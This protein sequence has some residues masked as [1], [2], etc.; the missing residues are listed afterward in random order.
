VDLT[1][2]TAS[3]ESARNLK[4]DLETGRVR[5]YRYDEYD[6]MKSVMLPKHC[7][8][9][10][11]TL[12]GRDTGF[13]TSVLARQATVYKRLRKKI[14]AL[15]PE[16]VELSRKWL[17]G[18]EIHLQDAVDYA[19]DLIRGKTPEDRIYLKKIRNRRDVAAAVLIDASSSTEET[20]SGRRI[21][22]IEKDA[23]CLLGQTLAAVGDDFGL[24]SFASNGRHGVF[25]NVVKDFADP[26]GPPVQARIGAIEA[27]ASN[28]DGCA[29]RHAS[30]VLAS[31][32]H[33]TKLLLLL[34]DG[35]PADVDYGSASNIETSQYAIEDT[36]QAI[37]DAKK[38][39]I[40]PYCLTIDRTA[41]DYIARLYGQ[42]HFQ[43]L[44][45]I[46]RLPEK[47][48]KLYL[49]LTR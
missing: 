47:L 44:S 39:G 36:R 22:D 40:V 7:T 1:A 25:F 42:Y 33:K 24:Y 26:W 32:P 45:D 20:V 30:A 8:L 15:K 6:C 5:V 18:D 29:V 11:R 34:S 23:V 9:Y 48:S 41:K 14:L 37:L 12:D 21:I 2:T 28:R 46:A 4:R 38:T 19:I 3:G 31:L 27:V 10:E 13:F 49:R 17:S 43:I 16:E 35:I